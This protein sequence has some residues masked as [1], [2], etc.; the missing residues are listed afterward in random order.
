MPYR[1]GRNRIDRVEPSPELTLDLG[2]RAP[3]GDNKDIRAGVVFRVCD[4]PILSRIRAEADHRDP[5]TERIIDLAGFVPF[6]GPDHQAESVEEAPAL[7]LGSH[8]SPIHDIEV[9][10][11]AEW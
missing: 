5:T 2:E 4:Q 6:Q 3:R 9:R 1:G 11:P 8:R 7:E 10:V